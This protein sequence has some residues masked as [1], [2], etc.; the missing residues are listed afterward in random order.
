MQDLLYDH[1]LYRTFETGRISARDFHS[2]VMSRLSCDLSFEE[3]S[4]LWNSLLVKRR[5]MFR[6]A[7][8]L[9]ERVGMLVLSNT[10]EINA[11]L[12]D[13]DIRA[14]TDKVVY[15][16]QVR[17]LKPDR[18]IFEEALQL[19]GAVPEEA[20]FI[21]DRSENLRGAEA[22]G[23]LTHHFQGRRDFLRTLKSYGL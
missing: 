11:S 8:R 1:D 2:T 14:L 22:L 15:S 20:L 18:Q 23:I 10:N 16:Y 5:S 6:T 19:S 9:K 13:P 7:H 3:F 17:C 21:D 4:A 12:M